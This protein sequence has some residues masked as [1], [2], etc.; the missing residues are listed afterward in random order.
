MWSD[1][2]PREPREPE[3]EECCGQG[4]AVCVWDR[5]ESNKVEYERKLDDWKR[6]QDV[7]RRVFMYTFMN[8]AINIFPFPALVQI[9]VNRFIQ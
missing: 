7:H 6:R 8:P 2:P 5:F 4:C 1:P 9:V 3:P